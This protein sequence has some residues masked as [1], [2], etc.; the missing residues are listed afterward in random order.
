MAL[1]YHF[2][3]NAGEAL[4]RRGIKQSELAR[5]AGIAPALLHS[6]LTYR[7]RMRGTLAWKI[8]RAYAGLAGVDEDQAFTSL[9]VEV[10]GNEEGT[11]PTERASS[12]L[13]VF[14]A[15]AQR[16]FDR[17]GLSQIELARQAGTTKYN[18]N[19]MMQGQRTRASTAWNIARVY[20][21]VTGVS[22]DNAFQLLFEES[23]DGR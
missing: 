16:H 7:N 18:I 12:S 10:E 2:I 13:Y 21:T 1:L 9:F 19:R 3:D 17:A 23:S 15:D 20:A 11:Q 5:S 14:K 4:A 8:A 6:K 22:H